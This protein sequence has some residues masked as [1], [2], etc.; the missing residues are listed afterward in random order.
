L[1]L[2]FNKTPHP[3]VIKLTPAEDTSNYTEVRKTK[4]SDADVQQPIF[5]TKVE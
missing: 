4:G 5:I 1:R 2:P 3:F